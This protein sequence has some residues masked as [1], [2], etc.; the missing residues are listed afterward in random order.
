M[1]KRTDLINWAYEMRERYNAPVYLVGSALRKRDPRDID[2]RIRMTNRDFGIRYGGLNWQIAAALWIVEG[3]TGHWGRTRW[4]W[5][6][7]CGNATFDAWDRLQ[8]NIDFQVYPASYWR[9]YT[10]KPRYK[11]A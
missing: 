11:L 5:A 7:E 6:R 8:L 10:G 4:K 3:K 9:E 2:I 1:R